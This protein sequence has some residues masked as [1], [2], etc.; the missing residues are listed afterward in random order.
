METGLYSTNLAEAAFLA[1]GAVS[2]ATD[3]AR[4]RVGRA[5]P[6]FDTRAMYE[7]DGS[8]ALAR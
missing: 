7:T 1:H 2:E 5:E 3:L 8:T 6:A 4:V